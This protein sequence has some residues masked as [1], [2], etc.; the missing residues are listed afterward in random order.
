MLITSSTK[1][2]YKYYYVFKFF[3]YSRIAYALFTY[4]YKLVQDVIMTNLK[5]WVRNNLIKIVLKQ[6]TKI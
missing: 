1:V 3:M 5:Q 2:V 6:V 4:G